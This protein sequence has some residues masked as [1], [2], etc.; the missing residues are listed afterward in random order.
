MKEESKV[1]LKQN[2]HHPSQP[3]L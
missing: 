1:R 3:G 2:C